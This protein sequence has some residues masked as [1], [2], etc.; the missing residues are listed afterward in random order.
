MAGF[1]EVLVLADVDF[2]ETGV[3]LTALFAGFAAGSAVLS[4]SE[5]ATSWVAA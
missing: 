4:C 3:S 1:V 2:E 5:T